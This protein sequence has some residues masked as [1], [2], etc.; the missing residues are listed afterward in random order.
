MPIAIN[1]QEW[2]VGMG[3]DPQG[4]RAF[5][6]SKNI[7]FQSFSPLCGPCGPGND[8]ELIT[9]KLVNDIADE[10]GKTGAQVALKW[11]VEN[12]SPVIART[13]SPVHLAQN[14][15]LFNWKL[16]D[17]EVARLN[18]AKSPPSVETVADDCKI[19]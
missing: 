3:P 7:T 8:R 5:C 14:M 12:G 18:A 13:N 17:E 9:G 10:H 6:D 16:T 1:Q 19:P 4:V 11:L 15:D 2:H